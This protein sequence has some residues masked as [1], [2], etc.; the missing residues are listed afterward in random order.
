MSFFMYYCANYS[1]LLLPPFVSPLLCG[2][3]KVCDFPWPH[4]GVPQLEKMV[5]LCRSM[6][7]WLK[8][9]NQNVLVMHCNVSLQ[10]RAPTGYLGGGE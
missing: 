10:D 4:N 1:F 7:A 9:D 3:L 8:A 2:M 5:D 6:D